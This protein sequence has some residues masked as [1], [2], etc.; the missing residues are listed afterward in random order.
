[1]IAA[2]SAAAK[3]RSTS[4]RCPRSGAAPASAANALTADSAPTPSTAVASTK[5]CTKSS[6]RSAFT[7]TSAQSTASASAAPSTCPLT[8][9]NSPRCPGVRAR[10]Q[11]PPTS[12]NRP[13][14][15]SGMASL[16]CSVTMRIEAPCA[17]PMPPPIVMPSISTIVGLPKVW[18]RWLS[19]YSSLKKSSSVGSPAN[20]A[21]WK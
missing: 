21:T 12:G 20:A 19:A 10:N 13:M 9:R 1:M 15:V 11:P 2:T 8:P 17:R 3:T 7:H 18:T 4:S 6:R 5:A 16:A 14:L